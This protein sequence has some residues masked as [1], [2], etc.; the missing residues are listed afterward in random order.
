[1]P[2]S[3]K[4]LADYAEDRGQDEDEMLRQLYVTEGKSMTAIAAMFDVSAAHVRTRLEICGIKQRPWKSSNRNARAW[5]KCLPTA[6][7]NW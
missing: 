2:V 7:W 3:A 4:Y 5:G 1:M 6:R